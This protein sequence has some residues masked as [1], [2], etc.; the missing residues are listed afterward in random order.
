[1]RFFTLLKRGG[2]LW[3]VRGGR[4]RLGG[5]TR[6]AGLHAGRMAKRGACPFTDLA[7][8]FVST[9][10]GISLLS[11]TP[12]ESMSEQRACFCPR[13]AS[14]ESGEVVLLGR[15]TVMGGLRSCPF[16][17]VVHFY[18][19]YRIRCQ[20]SIL[21][22]GGSGEVQTEETFYDGWWFFYDG[23][24]ACEGLLRVHGVWCRPFLLNIQCRR[25]G[26]RA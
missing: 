24:S 17:A 8:F 22:V 3:G 11:S 23:R 19:R 9:R 13:L 5:G 26:G 20:D 2:G 4:Y 15:G 16:V 7:H 25:R 14:L 6:G 12:G 10:E 18:R 21:C 1:V